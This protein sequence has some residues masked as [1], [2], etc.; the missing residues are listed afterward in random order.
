MKV[1]IINYGMGNINSVY[2]SMEIIGA[3]VHL[4]NSPKEMDNYNRFILPGVGAF[5]NGM[6]NLREGD[7]IEG[8]ERQVIQKGKNILGICIGLQLMATTGYE[9]GCF[10]GL[11]WVK[12]SVV[13]ISDI[14]GKQDLKLPHIGWNSVIIN[15]KEGLFQNLHDEEDFY[16]INTYA[17]V[18]EETEVITSKTNYYGDFVTSIHK[19]N[20]YAVQFHPE[21]SQKAG[22]IVF[23]NFLRMDD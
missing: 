18:P 23:E 22:Q 4:I 17:I 11:D 6:D 21:K 13:K 1:G 12:G 8:L 5:G 16:F 9:F 20:I 14:T 15:T 3:D 7:W 10:K 2:N 19:D